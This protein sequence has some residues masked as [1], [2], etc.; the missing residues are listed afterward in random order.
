M[1]YTRLTIETLKSALY[2]QVE[3]GSFNE[4]PVNDAI[5]KLKIGLDSA[6]VKGEPT[7]ELEQFIRD[8]EFI[9]YDLN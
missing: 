6:I 3:T 8:L 7:T 5:Q 2:E 4:G 1:S 9:K